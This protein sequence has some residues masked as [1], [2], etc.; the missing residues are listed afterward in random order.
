MST[1]TVTTIDLEQAQRGLADKIEPL[2]KEADTRGPYISGHSKRV[3]RY[4][5]GTAKELMLPPEQITE[6]EVAAKLHDIGKASINQQILRKKTQ[7]T[8]HEWKVLREHPLTSSIFLENSN[9]PDTIVT[10]VL[11]HHERVDGR[12]Y[13]NSKPGTQIPVGAKIISIA[14]AFD[15]MTVSNTYRDVKTLAE[16]KK[17]LLD[18]SGT[19]FDP[20]IVKAFIKFL[21]KSF[22]AYIYV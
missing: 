10:L 12:G 4:A 1:M 17:E 18:N 19:Q 7:L 16:A 8:E 5:V 22:N 2:A 14:D 13:P 6:I 21:N 11:N 3:A 15:A 20:R 9:F